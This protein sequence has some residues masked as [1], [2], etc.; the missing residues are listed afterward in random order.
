M[1]LNRLQKRST[2]SLRSSRVPYQHHCR[3]FYRFGFLFLFTVPCTHQDQE[4]QDLSVPGGEGLRSVEALDPS[5]RSN[6]V[7]SLLGSLSRLTGPRKPSVPGR[8]QKGSTLMVEGQHCMAHGVVSKDGG[9]GSI[10]GVERLTNQQH[11]CSSIKSGSP[12]QP[13]RIIGT[14]CPP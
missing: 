5:K 3:V 4:L 13:N 9:L 10:T 12:F 2:C 14:F 11:G 7:C 8:V 1:I 6:P